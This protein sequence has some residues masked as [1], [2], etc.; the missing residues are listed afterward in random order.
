MFDIYCSRCGEPVSQD[1]LHNPEELDGPE[2]LT[3]EQAAHMFRAKG[4]GL[5][6]PEPSP[7]SRP[8]VQAVEKLLAIKAGQSLSEHPDEWAGFI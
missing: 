2:N 3:Y 1:Y 7:C 5:F 4:C 6:Q 8:R